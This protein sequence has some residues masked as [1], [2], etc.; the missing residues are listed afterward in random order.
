[1]RPLDFRVARSRVAIALVAFLACV[2]VPSVSPPATLAQQQPLHLGELSFALPGPVW[3][4]VTPGPDSRTVLLQKDVAVRSQ[5]VSIQLQFAPPNASRADVTAKALDAE[6][7]SPDKQFSTSDY[8]VGQ[9]T[10]GGISYGTL[11]YHGVPSGGSPEPILDAVALIWIPP[12]FEDRGVY[13]TVRWRDVHAALV[14]PLA[15]DELDTLVQ[16]LTLPPLFSPLLRDD[17]Q[18]PDASLFHAEQDDQFSAGF[19]DG[20]FAVQKT[21]PTWTGGWGSAASGGSFANV[22]VM[23]DVRAASSDPGPLAYVACRYAYSPDAGTTGYRAAV[24]FSHAAF[25]IQRMDGNQIVRLTSWRTAPSITQ[26]GSPVHIELDCESTSIGMSVNGGPGVSVN[27]ST[28]MIGSTAIAAGALS[29]VQGLTD[30]RFD[31]FE[32]QQG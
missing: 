1:M 3:R 2:A 10:I 15:L 28:Y 30:V 16:S 14:G 13:Y 27:D 19:V 7:K 31:S 20:E 9:R 29:D 8:R 12:N 11:S 5:Y 26:D 6:Q 18:S 25:Q 23:A 21:D 17:F 32:V 24:D 4:Q 22:I